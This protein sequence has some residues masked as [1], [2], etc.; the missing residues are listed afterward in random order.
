VG[1]HI[2]RVKLLGVPTDHRHSHRAPHFAECRLLARAD[3][4]LPL[5]TARQLSIYIEPPNVVVHV[6]RNHNREDQG[7][8]VL[9][10][11][12]QALSANA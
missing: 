8:Y 4:E 7:D 12:S 9:L 3:R 6:R 2:L 10:P 1:L 11:T 5:H